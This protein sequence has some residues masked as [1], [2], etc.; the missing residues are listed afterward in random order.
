MHNAGVMRTAQKGVHAPAY[1]CACSRNAVRRQLHELRK[2]G[3]GET[4]AEPERIVRR[5]GIFIRDRILQHRIVIQGVIHIQIHDKMGCTLDAY[6]V[7][8]PVDPWRITADNLLIQ[9][10]R[11][12]LAVG[13]HHIGIIYARLLI[14]VIGTRLRG[15][16][17]VAVA[18]VPLIPHNVRLRRIPCIAII[19]I[20]LVFIRFD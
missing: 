2:S 17:G 16:G 11:A 18:P 8:L 9:C 3:I 20:K 14:Y 5:T 13:K 12:A 7:I 15:D 1:T 4:G 19:R 6:A 10:V